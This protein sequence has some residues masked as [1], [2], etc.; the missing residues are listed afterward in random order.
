MWKKHPSAKIAVWIPDT[1]TTATAVAPVEET[2]KATEA[3]KPAKA[4]KTDKK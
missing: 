1:P 3:K 4:K 2:A